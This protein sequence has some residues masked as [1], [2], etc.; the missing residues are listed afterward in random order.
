MVTTRSL[1]FQPH[2]FHV[3]AYGAA[4]DGKV[5]ADGSMSSSVNPTHLACTTSTPFASGDVGK[6]V[7]VSTAGGGTYSPL[8]TTISTFTDSGHVVLGA[9]AT[10]TTTGTPGAITYFG[11]DDTAAI[12]SAVSAAVTYAQANNGYAEVIFDPLIY[13]IAGAATVG[14]G[15][16]GNAQIPLPVISDTDQ[17]IVLAFKG[18]ADSG[19]A[20]HWLQ[21]VP[22]AAGTVL[23]CARADGTNDGTY[24]PASVIGGP[25]DG[26]GAQSTGPGNVWSNIEPVIDGIKIVVPYNSTFSGFDFYGCANA[27]VPNAACIAAAVVPTSS[28]VPRNFDPLN[29]ITNQWTFGIRMPS[30]NNN[31]RCDIGYFTA[32]GLTWGVQAS[33]HTV[34]ES[35]RALYCIVGLE[36]YDGASLGAGSHGMRVNYASVEACTNALGF[37]VEN[38]QKFVDISMVDMETCGGLV[39]DPNN[40]AYGTVGFRWCGSGAAPTYFSSMPG[41][42]SS[43]GTNLRFIQLHYPSGP[44]A[45][46]QAPPATTVAWFNGY[47]RDAWITVSLSGGNTFTSLNIDSTAQPNAAGAGKYEFLL[48]SGHS[49]TPAYSAGTLTHTVT[50][51]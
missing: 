24:G 38:T 46:P 7:L 3:A 21:T 32:Y 4:G 15:T 8:A 22:Q 30:N 28:T 6:S 20:L 29:N 5:V 36:G 31:D 41:A 16:L 25:F 43:G 33:E 44:V 18:A 26:Y 47:Y 49:Y 13:I 48:P 37:S 51:L 17:K 35:M 2:Q 9:S 34:I 1:P 45:S 11:T 50:L 27:Y 39:Y 40:N 12:N 10:S 42:N 14:G 19:E 23:A